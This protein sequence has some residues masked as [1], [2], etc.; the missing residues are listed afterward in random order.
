[1]MLFSKKQSS[2]DFQRRLVN[3]QICIWS[4]SLCHIRLPGAKR[5]RKGTR[6]MGINENLLVFR[7]NEAFLS[8]SP[9]LW[10][11]TRW[12]NLTWGKFPFCRMT[13]IDLRIFNQFITNLSHRTTFKSL[14]RVVENYFKLIHKCLDPNCR[15]Q[16]ISVESC[17]FILFG[18]RSLFRIRSDVLTLFQAF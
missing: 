12:P 15:R 1:M 11:R 17:S 14:S 6:R 4:L 7:N 13:E 16:L 9:I 8:F 18:V 2:I 10:A 3:S 5:S